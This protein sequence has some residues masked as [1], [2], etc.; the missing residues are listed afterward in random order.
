MP[1]KRAHELWVLLNLCKLFVNLRAE[2]FTLAQGVSRDACALH[3]TPHQ[4]IRIEVRCIAGQKVQG[5]FGVSASNVVFRDSLFVCRQSVDNQ[6]NRPL[7]IEHQ[8]LEQRDEQFAAESPFVRR[9]PESA[10]RVD[11]G[12]RAHTLP[13]TGALY[14]GRLAAWRPGLAMYRVGPKARFVPE[15]DVRLLLTSPSGD[16]WIRVVLP[17][18]DCLRIALVS[19]LQRLLRCQVQ[20]RQHCADRGQAQRDTEFTLYQFAYQIASP[21]PEVKAILH[22]VLAIDPAQHLLLLGGSELAR[23][24]CRLGRP[25]CTHSSSSPPG[26]RPQLVCPRTMHTK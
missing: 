7:P 22:W 24:A 12:R 1:E 16:G 3:V 20:T 10:L 9:K 5:Q 11:G 15:E 18:L 6:M 26:L 21:K 19:M 8:L 2:L 17:A 4:L 13:L 25:Q 14:D 23:A